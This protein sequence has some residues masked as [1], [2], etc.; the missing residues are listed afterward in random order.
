[1][2]SFRRESF[3]TLFG[4]PFKSMWERFWVIEVYFRG[5]KKHPWTAT[6]EAASAY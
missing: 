2:A 3:R 5:S 6:E 4:P 1:M